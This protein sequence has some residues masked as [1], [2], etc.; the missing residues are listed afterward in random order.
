MGGS[1][2]RR[3]GTVQ[4]G[5]SG[6]RS[7]PSPQADGLR[8]VMSRVTGEP[9]AR[10]GSEEGEQPEGVAEGFLEEVTPEVSVKE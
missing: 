7:C 5:H 3:W 1:G 10:W 4:M 2:R 6:A 8:R 9:R